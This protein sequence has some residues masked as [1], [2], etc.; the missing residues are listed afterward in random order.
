MSGH[1]M[2]CAYFMQLSP[3][4]TLR[5]VILHRVKRRRS[6]QKSLRPKMR[7]ELRQQGVALGLHLAHSTATPRSLS[8]AAVGVARNS[9]HESPRNPGN[10]VQLN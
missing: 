5:H 3:R 4:S 10:V 1:G 6:V 9:E 7:F 8:G 2:P